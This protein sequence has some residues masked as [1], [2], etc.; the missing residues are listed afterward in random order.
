LALIG[1][2]TDNIGNSRTRRVS[3]ISADKDLYAVSS[4]S[5]AQSGPSAI[6]LA[7]V[8][9]AEILGLAGY[10][11]VP[12]LLPQFI[13]AWSLTNTQAGWLAGIVSAGYMLAVVPLVRLTDRQPARLIYLASSILSALSCFGVALCDSLL[14]ALVFRAVT[15]IALAGMYMPG[16]QAL[17]H[18]VEGT[19]R[20]RIAAWYTS[21]F[22]V[23]TSLSFLLGRIG[24]VLGWRS[25]FVLAG[26]LSSAAVVIAWAALPRADPG[27]RETPKSLIDFRPVFA[28]RDALILIFGYAAAIWGSAGLRQWIV[29]FLA[30]CA[31][32][33]AG[34]PA[35][36]WIILAVGA[37]ISLLGVPA[38]LLGNE[39]S[40]RY[41]LRNIATLVFLLSALT[42]GLFGFTAMLPYVAVLCLSVVA[43]FILQGNFSNLTSGVL[44]VAAP[45]HRGATIGLYS[46]VGFGGGFL[47]TLVFGVTL[48]QFG[49]ASQ[50]AAWI[51][52]FATC[53]LAC[54]AGSAATIFL[55]RDIWRPRQ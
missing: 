33:R 4:L 36:A 50:L 21:S 3:P 26:I 8:C 52:S 40:I 25:A 47:G 13:E 44:A 19:R 39:M 46:C 28:S 55:S 11:T 54:L 10:S 12:A 45:Q 35:Q 29:A 6:I 49:R 48:D 5:S 27:F 31:A 9:G 16:L 17:T 41:G 2:F 18:G 1:V 37:L 42:G 34:V 30:F 23:G 14:P 24:T 43:G 38:G 32:H 22:T 53:G 7:A 20:A 15:G 51:L